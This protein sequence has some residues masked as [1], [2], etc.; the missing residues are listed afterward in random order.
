MARRQQQ[1]QQTAAVA[2]RLA[3]L[4]GT[5]YNSVAVNLQ[6]FLIRDSSPML[7][8][9]LLHL[10]RKSRTSAKLLNRLPAYLTGF[11]PSACLPCAISFINNIQYKRQSFAIHNP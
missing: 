5:V 7:P 8:M 11:C 1:Q 6:Q 3:P 2:S 10:P 9:L 4:R